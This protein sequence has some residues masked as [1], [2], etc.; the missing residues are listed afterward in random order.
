IYTEVLQEDIEPAVIAQ[1]RSGVT[2]TT[3]VFMHHSNT[4]ND[5]AQ[6]YYSSFNS[7]GQTRANALGIPSGFTHVSDPVR[8]RTP[9]SSHGAN[10]IWL[11]GVAIDASI[12]NRLSYW[13]SDDG[14][15]T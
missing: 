13:C 12:N 14:G 15:F 2:Y 10:R 9:T 3:T 4:F 7:S 8:A 5:P 6:F 11:A 1:D